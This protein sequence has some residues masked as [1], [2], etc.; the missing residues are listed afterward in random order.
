MENFNAITNHVYSEKNQIELEDH[1]DEYGLDSD[2]WAGFTQWKTKG[3]KVCKGE[4]GCAIKMIGTKKTKN[5]LGEEKKKTFPVIKHVFNILQT[6]EIGK[7][8]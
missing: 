8:A 1:K 4:K 6:E 7:P 5:K 3:R 2:L